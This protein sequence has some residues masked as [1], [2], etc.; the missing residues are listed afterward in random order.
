MQLCMMLGNL[1][2]RVTGGVSSCGEGPSSCHSSNSFSHNPLSGIWG[3]FPHVPWYSFLW[4]LPIHLDSFLSLSQNHPVW[5]QIMI[6][7]TFIPHVA[8]LKLSLEVPPFCVDMCTCWDEKVK[9]HKVKWWR[10]SVAATSPGPLLER[11]A[12][13]S[14]SEW[15]GPL[16][17]VPH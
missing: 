6:K 8:F 14:S 17:T 3:H 5:I 11:G 16:L 12:A 10:T 13:A 15:E 7:S 4:K 2:Q 9:L 1:L